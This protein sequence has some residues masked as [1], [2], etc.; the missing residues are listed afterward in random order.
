MASK[1]SAQSS[2]E[3]AI[4]PDL[5]H[6]PR[7]RHAA[8]AA[9]PAEGRSQARGA[10][11]P[12]GRDDAA[13]RLAADGEADQSRGG[14][15]GRAGRRAARARRGSHGLRVLPPNHWSPIARAPSGQ[16]GHQHGAGF[17]EP[18]RDRGLLV[19]HP[20][21]E[22][23]GA[24][25]RRI[26]RVGD[27]V[28]GAPGNAVQRPAILARGDLGVGLRGLLERQILGERDDALQQRVEPLEPAEIELRQLGRA[29]LAG[30]DQGR[31]LGDRQERQSL[32]RVG[33][34]KCGRCRSAWPG[35]GR[36]P[37]RPQPGAGTNA[38]AGGTS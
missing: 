15:R 22:L 36:P 19:D 20:V 29:E 33:P 27:Q 21:L 11:G 7:E 10:A 14:R 13:E 17:L 25:G 31:K 37:G 38:S 30:A 16:L 18:G 8:V 35:C 12:A 24:P 32:V 2:I 1:T 34:P 6:R 5:V 26:A 28:L 9:H 23:R 4:G 3:R